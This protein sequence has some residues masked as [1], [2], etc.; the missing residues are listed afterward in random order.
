VRASAGMDRRLEAI[1]EF[2]GQLSD[3]AATFVTRNEL[4]AV[5]ER[6][7]ALSSRQD[8]QEGSGSGLRAGWGFLVGGIGAV[9]VIVTVIVEIVGH[10]N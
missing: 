7:N 10:A 1:N 6:I 9:A 5:I 8:R 2:R 3:Q 4:Q